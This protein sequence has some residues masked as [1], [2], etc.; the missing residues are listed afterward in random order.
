ML[1]RSW[2][3]AVLAA[4]VLV[5][6][7]SKQAAPSILG[8]WQA[9][10]VSVFSA[11]LPIGPDIVVSEHAISSPD[12]GVGLTVKGIERNGDEATVDLAY[13]VGLSFYFDG[14]DRMYLKV[15]LVGPVYYRRV[16]QDVVASSSAQ[17]AAA[18]T[19]PSADDP[20]RNGVVASAARVV[21]VDKQVS[22]LEQG[23]QVMRSGQYGRAEELLTKAGE[24]LS[25]HP[26]VDYDL[27]SLAARKG[28]A[29]EAIRHL[30]DAFKAGF[31]KFSRLESAP[32]FASLRL[33]VRYQALVAHYR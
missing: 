1:F 6:A 29:D 8:H 14:P 22:L 16:T 21:P 3:A 2:K 27:A 18:S 24:N 12:A 31:R 26:A 30:N 11:Q 15:P 33:D 25:T 7:C 13:G 9:E 23:E 19:S 28:D 5:T 10:R 4:L 17:P 32:E 20:V